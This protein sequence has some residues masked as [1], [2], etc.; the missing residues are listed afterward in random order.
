MRRSP[1]FQASRP[2][3]HEPVEMPFSP[4]ETG[5]GRRTAALPRPLP[6]CPTPSF[7]FLLRFSASCPV[8]RPLGRHVMNLIWVGLSPFLHAG[9]DCT[10][11][12]TASAP[13]SHTEV[14]CPCFHVQPVARPDTRLSFLKPS[15]LLWNIPNP[16]SPD[17]PRPANP[18]IYYSRNAASKVGIIPGASFE[19]C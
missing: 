14:Y 17:P 1:M 12:S 19:A 5:D 11:S 6:N 3:E 7:S 4:L 18:C 15:G 2:I 13:K 8:P 9:P 10:S 16:Q